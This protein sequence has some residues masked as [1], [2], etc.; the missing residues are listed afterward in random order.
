M[1]DDFYTEEG[2]PLQPKRA[3][4]DAESFPCPTLAQ[5]APDPQR[6]IDFA[7]TRFHLTPE[8]TAALKAH[9]P[10]LLTTIELRF[11]GTRNRWIRT[12]LVEIAARALERNAESWFR[13]VM[14]AS[15]PPE[16]L[17][18]LHPGHDCLSREDGLQFA[19]ASLAQLP[20]KELAQAC[21]VLVHFRAHA[22][23][24]WIESN[25][26]EPITARW[27]D[28]AAASAL[29][30]PRVESRLRTGRPLSLVALDALVACSGPLPSQSFLTQQMQ[31]RLHADVPESSIEAALRAYAARDR[32]PRVSSAVNY[33]ISEL[34]VIV[35]ARPH[36]A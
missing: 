30:S 24:D 15:E 26:H 28:V 5:C 8:L 13:Q 4:T 20:K 6:L 18:Y 29:D 9:A 33:I 12:R 34:T 14:H 23:L 22:T 7:L 11:A 27:G 3:V 10:H 2:R 35:S 32:S 31:P 21:L 25:V 19:Q 36:D 17:S 16:L 1:H